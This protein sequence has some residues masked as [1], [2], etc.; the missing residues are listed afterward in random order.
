MYL[1]PDIA[2]PG[3]AILAAWRA[4]DTEVVL[5]G[6]EPPLFNFLSGT[7]VSS[8][9]VS[10]IA[11]ILKSENRT[12]SPSAIKSAIMTTPVHESNLKSPML[13]NSAYGNFLAT[14]Y[15]F[16][17]GVATISRSLKPGLVYETENQ[18]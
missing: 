6:H 3:T 15:D 9:H 12:W 8:R 13:I 7:S 2:A 5:A 14:P 18:V 4:N 1:Q 16:G 10:A 17:A 11:A